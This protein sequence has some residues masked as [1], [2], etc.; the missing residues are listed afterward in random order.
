MGGGGVNANG[1]GD[2]RIVIFIYNYTINVDLTKLYFWE[3]NGKV[4][5]MGD[6]MGSG[7]S[8]NRI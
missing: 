4:W 1:I 6:R 8:E 7:G 3:H 5:L 2:K